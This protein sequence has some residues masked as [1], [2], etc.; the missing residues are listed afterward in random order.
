MIKTQEKRNKT[1]SA[2]AIKKTPLRA[3]AR[4]KKTPQSPPTLL[5]GKKRPSG[6]QPAKNRPK[7]APK[8][9]KT[10]KPKISIKSVAQ[11]IVKNQKNAPK[12]I[13]RIQ[14]KTP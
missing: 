4:N 14:A 7:N 5:G 8:K 1:N 9:I 3:N 10:K 6:Q 2:S 12:I 11:I 13:R